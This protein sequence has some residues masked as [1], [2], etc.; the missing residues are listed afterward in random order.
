MSAMYALDAGMVAE[1]TVA[2]MT[3]DTMSEMYSSIKA[4]NA[5]TC[6]ALSCCEAGGFRVRSVN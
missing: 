2:C 6:L 4:T 5:A 1:N 3:R